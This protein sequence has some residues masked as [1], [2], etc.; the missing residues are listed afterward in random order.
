VGRQG[1]GQK[2]ADALFRALILERSDGPLMKGWG[3][4]KNIQGEAE[5]LEQSLYYRIT[6]NGSGMFIKGRVIKEKMD[7]LHYYFSG[8]VARHRLGTPFRN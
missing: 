2:G 1:I 5:F 3:T 8:E 6:Q 7:L 4:R